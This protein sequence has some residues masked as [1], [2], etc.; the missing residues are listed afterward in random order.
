MPSGKE[1]EG[2]DGSDGSVKIFSGIISGIGEAEVREENELSDGTR[3]M[4]VFDLDQ[5]KKNYPGIE[6]DPEKT[7]G[8]GS[9]G[10]GIVIRTRRPGDFI[11]TGVGRKKIQNMLVDMKIPKELRDSFRRS[12]SYGFPV[13]A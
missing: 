12:S 2:R 9:T 10:Q 7:E 5:L 1:T 3:V 13:T 11:Q 8:C 4:A 6:I